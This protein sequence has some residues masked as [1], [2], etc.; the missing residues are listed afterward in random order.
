MASS[1]RPATARHEPHPPTALL[2]RPGTAL[3]RAEDAAA[4]HCAHGMQPARVRAVLPDAYAG[5]ARGAIRIPVRRRTDLPARAGD[6]APSAKL[7]KR[8]QRAA[9]HIVIVNV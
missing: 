3:A 9:G 4:V 5:G 2:L 6:P 8:V 1:S 7:E